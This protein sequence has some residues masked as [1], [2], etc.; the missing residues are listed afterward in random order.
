MHVVCIATTPLQEWKR[1]V[2]RGRSADA[3]GKSIDL[4]L[5]FADAKAGQTT[6]PAF[7]AHALPIGYWAQVV[8]YGWRGK[9]AMATDFACAQ[10]RLASAKSLWSVTSG[11]QPHV[12]RPLIALGGHRLHTG[13]SLT[14]KVHNFFLML[15][16]PRW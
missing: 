11:P 13:M 1:E 6:D 5:I 9:H 2:A 15:I 3:A 7:A 12:L 16:R 4:A 8:W 14:M 10:R